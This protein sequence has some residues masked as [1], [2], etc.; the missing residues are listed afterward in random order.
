M[1][2]RRDV[3]LSFAQLLLFSATLPPPET[4]MDPVL[5]R[6][7]QLLEDESLVDEVLVA[8]R[9]RYAQSSRRGRYGTPAEVV[10]RM[11]VLKH[12]RQWTYEALCREV[13]GSLVYRRFCRIDAGRVPD[14]KTMVKLGQLVEGPALRALFD[15]VVQQAVEQKVTRGAKL[16][17][18]TTVVEA[19]I[20][21][22]TDSRLCEDVVRVL[23][24]CLKRLVTA[25]V[26]LSFKVRDV[27]RQVGRRM[28][29]VTQAI[30][31]RG[32][33][34]RQR[35]L[36]KPYRRLL[37]V[38][39]RLVRQAVRACQETPAQLRRLGR[40]SRGQVQRTLKHLEQMIPRGHQVVRQTRARVLRGKTRSAGK[41]VS[42][43]EPYAQILRRGKPHRPTEFGVMV[44]V[45]ETE[46]GIV[47]DVAIDSDKADAPLLA[48]TVEQHRQIF[49]RAPRMVATDR[50][51]YSA[52]GE[53]RLEEIGVRHRVIPKPGY[54]S[55]ARLAHERQ[56]WFRR[57]RAWRAGGEARIGHLKHSFGMERS[58]YRGQAG[59]QRTI[60]WAAMANNLVTICRA[61]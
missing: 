28:R 23:G 40:R 43:F 49:G 32:K 51:F 19:P 27:R 47:S 14:D 56:R 50:A 54:R 5:R 7:D 1:V 48:P 22:P 26:K 11:L 13:A 3:Q 6:M 36:E 53:Q 9:R 20:H 41:L 34:Q 17:L 4:L 30:R 38:T 12:V 10:L 46:G 44:K 42:I 39:G 24:R 35:A 16:R 8:L 33:A 61:G 58:V 45:A 31:L 55:P 2:R 60:L 52:R 25:G 18:D 29:E 15:R 57:G 37:R 59:L 21:H